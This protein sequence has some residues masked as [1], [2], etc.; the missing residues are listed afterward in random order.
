MLDLL[1]SSVLNQAA[2]TTSVAAVSA[3]GFVLCAV[4]S[5]LCGL[6][7]AFVY[8][9][10]HDYSKGFVVTLAIMPVI[11]QMVILLVNGNLGAGIAV[12]GV[13]NLVRF[14][15]IAGTAKDIGSVFLAMAIGLATGMG[16]LGLAVLLTVVVAILN[17][18]YVTSGFGEAADQAKLLKITVP[19][20]L[21]FEGM[22]DQVLSRYSGAFRLEDIETTN[23]GSLYQL[24]YRIVLREGASQKDLIDDLRCLNGNLKISLSLAPVGKE[25]L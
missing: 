1:F 13:F 11:V 17:F 3:S 2:S 14:R 10:R 8:M 23:M 20:D 16:Y 19:E 15:S 9:Y 21:Q 24:R 18:V 6:A 22:F 25:M 5:I 4:T 12:M 7:C